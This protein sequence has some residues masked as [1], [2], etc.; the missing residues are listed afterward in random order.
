[1]TAIA[2]WE[3]VGLNKPDSESRTPP[4]TEP[5]LPAAQRQKAHLSIWS[6]M[7]ITTVC[8]L[9][10]AAGNQMLQALR[11][12]NL[13]RSK[14]VLFTLTAPV[15]TLVLISVIRAVYRIVIGRR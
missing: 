8:C 15:I 1:M 12:D 10:A 7:L 5:L 11:S 4:D 6:L 14:F 2:C 9:M 13:P 3:V